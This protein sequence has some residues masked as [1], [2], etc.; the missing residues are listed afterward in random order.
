MKE[1]L[2]KIKT[3]AGVQGAFI[4]DYRGEVIASSVSSGL[5]M[6]TLNGIGREVALTMAILEKA[7][8]TI[9][10]LDFTYERMRLLVRDIPNVV[11]VVL[12]DPQIEIAMLRLT[13]NVVAGR[14]KNDSEIE[15]QLAGRVAEKDLAQD[16]IDKTSFQLLKILTKGR[17]RQ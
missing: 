11:V 5:D 15:R 13:L 12:C 3:V 17:K 6:V 10:E 9:D 4:C 8:E 16:D 7:G 1:G 14:F 2:A